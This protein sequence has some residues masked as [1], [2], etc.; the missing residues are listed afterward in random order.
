MSGIEKF[1]EE[2][3]LVFAIPGL[4]AGAAVTLPVQPNS[5]LRQLRAEIA[6]WDK[7]SDSKQQRL[8]L[9]GDISLP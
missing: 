5:Q 6:L 9:A 3:D 1:D 4:E 8:S 7:Q 2:L